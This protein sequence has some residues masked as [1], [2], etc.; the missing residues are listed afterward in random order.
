MN[1]AE[2]LDSYK[3]TLID[4]EELLENA[5]NE[6]DVEIDYESGNDTLTISYGNGTVAII[7]RQSAICQLWLAAVSGGFHFDRDEESGQWICTINGRTLGDMLEE[8][9]L[10][11]GGVELSFSGI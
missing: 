9:C 10:Q 6:Q 5:I 1:E 8:I 2:F 7:S 11:Q 3:Q 4:I